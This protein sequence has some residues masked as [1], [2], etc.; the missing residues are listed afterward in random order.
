[1]FGTILA[2]EIK[3]RIDSNFCDLSIFAMILFKDT[4]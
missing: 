2:E 3:G 4:Y 1:M